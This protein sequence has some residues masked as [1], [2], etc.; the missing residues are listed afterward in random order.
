MIFLPDESKGNAVVELA[1]RDDALHR[2][3]LDHLETGIYMVDLRRKIL[4]WNHAAEQITG[5]L[6]Q[7]VAG[8]FCFDDLMMHC[9]GAGR[10]LCGKACPL[11][12]VMLDGK[13]RECTIFLRHRHGHRIP[14]L[15]RSRAI[16]D[17]AGTIIGAVEVFEKANPAAAV[18]RQIL[19]AHGCLDPLTEVANR[20]FGEFKLEQ[21]LS[22]LTSFG[23]PFAWIAAELENVEEL[24]HRYGHGMI[25][26]AM[27]ML[28]KTLESNVG[29]FDK[30]TRWH[31]TAFRIEAHSFWQQGLDELIG[32]LV[33]LSRASNVD[34]WGDP[35]RVTLSIAGVLA[36]PEDTKAALE[37]RVAERL[38]R[39]RANKSGQTIQIGS[40]REQG[41]E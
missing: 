3:L 8:Q 23:I 28:A 29:N 26:S 33:T 30:L 41:E 32:K 38:E 39:V 20:A 15:V 4:Y 18:D 34:W 17:S 12:N 37:A 16:H 31:N 6:S 27:K 22:T 2:A 10:G 36:E 19:D 5:Y 25:D 24:Q 40:P 9:D 14:V 7:H 21:A 11:S 13:P 1:L 35:V